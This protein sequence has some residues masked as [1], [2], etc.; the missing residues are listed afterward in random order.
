M[1]RRMIVREV[2][3]VSKKPIAFLLKSPFVKAELPER[4]T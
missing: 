2:F 4:I 3:D 1:W